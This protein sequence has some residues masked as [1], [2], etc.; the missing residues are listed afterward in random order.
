[1]V[2]RLL[3]VLMYLTMSGGGAGPSWRDD[4]ASCSRPKGMEVGNESRTAENYPKN[5][6]NLYFNS[7]TVWN[8]I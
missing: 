1:M 8:G 6:G 3:F 7:F 4:G 5:E 2:I